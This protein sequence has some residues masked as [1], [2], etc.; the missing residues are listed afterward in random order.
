MSIVQEVSVQRDLV[1]DVGMHRG[2][3]AEFYLKKGFRVVAIEANGEIAKEVSTRLRQYIETGALTVLNLAIADRQGH[4]D[5]Y[6]SERDGWGCLSSERASSGEQLQIAS[7]RVSVPCETFLSILRAHGI[8]Y[9]LK[10]DIE[11]SDRLCIDTLREVSAKPPYLSFE[12]DLANREETFSIL[13]LLWQFGYRRFKVLNQALNA[14]LRCPSPPRE[15]R[16]CDVRFTRYMSGP[17]GEETPGRWLTIDEARERYSRIS[18][19]QSLRTRYSTSGR[20][21]GLPLGRFHAQLER[22]YNA[23]PVRLLRTLYCRLTGREMGG[24]FD[25]HAALGDV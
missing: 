5:F 6:V 10:I 9:Y 7:R 21:F 8:P 2:E 11:G 25:I 18:R 1:F 24:W 23:A 17:F 19:Q 4:A 20:V 14:S 13:S 12:C 15:G 22:F 16:H 3:D